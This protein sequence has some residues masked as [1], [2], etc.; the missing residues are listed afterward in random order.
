M[1]RALAE[2]APANPD[3]ARQTALLGL[4]NALTALAG[5]L[6]TCVSA[7][8]D[9]TRLTERASRLATQAWDVRT[10]RWSFQENT[11]K[12]ADSL[13]A[14]ARE[15]AAASVRARVESEENS[16]VIEALVT[17]AARIGRLG[18][19]LASGSFQ[20][21]IRAELEPLEATLLALRNRVANESTVT[22]DAA[23]L[24]RRA[25]EMAEVALRLRGGGRQADEAAAAISRAL[26]AFIGDATTI[27]SRMATASSNIS[28]VA[29]RMAISAR[30]AKV[31]LFSRGEK[32]D[33]VTR[34]VW[35]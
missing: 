15:A 27:S 14:F 3:Q 21:A 2:S 19:G 24:A 4:S 31:H 16:V 29:S 7:S 35:A 12:L 30:D 28:D 22:E 34:K 33:P 5:K 20:S 1:E 13:V 9:F 10:S 11:G 25:G 32:M 26:T 23:G 8:T 17:Q 6:R 18:Q